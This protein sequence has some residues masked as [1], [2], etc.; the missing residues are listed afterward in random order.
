[1]QFNNGANVVVTQSANDVEYVLIV[2]NSHVGEKWI[3]NIVATFHISTSREL[4][5]SYKK[6]TDS[7][8]LM[9]GK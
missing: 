7:T 6:C 3:L 5:S 8:L 2:S 9:D 1:M 4:F